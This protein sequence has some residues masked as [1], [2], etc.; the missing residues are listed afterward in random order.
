MMHLSYVSF[1]KVKALNFKDVYYQQH[2]PK[3]EDFYHF[4]PT[5][6]GLSHAIE[7]RKNFPV[8]RRL[9]V[10]VL[11]SHYTKIQPSEKQ[12]FNISKLAEDTT[13]TIVTAHQPS[14]MGGPAY[15]FY[16]IFS[17]L[18]LAKKLKETYPS[19]HFVPLFINGSE[20]HDFDEVKSL[21]LF[22]KKISWETDQKGS[23]GRFMTTG[24]EGVV[25]ELVEILGPNPKAQRLSEI[26][27]NALSGAKTYNDFVFSW[28][29]AF[30][31]DYGLIV[32]N[33]DD[34]RLKKSFIPIFTKEIT[35]RISEKL[36]HETQEKLQKIGF[37]PQAFARDINIFY[38]DGTSRERIYYQAG[39][40]KVNNSDLTFDEGQILEELNNFP[41]KFS[42][43]VVLRPLYEETILPNIAY[44]GG[45][46]ELAY[47]LERKSQFEAFGVFFP[48]LIRRNSVM[49]IPKSIQKLMEKLNITQ[50]DILL[51]EDKLI[52]RFL[53]ISSTENFHLDQESEKMIEI[54]HHI[55]EKAKNVDP[56]L[57]SYVLGEGHKVS[58]T[59]ENIENR[60]KRALKHKEE[61]NINQIKAIKHK[62]FPNNSLQ[63]RVDSF[64]QYLISEEDDLTEKLI[65]TLDPLEKTFLFVYL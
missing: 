51:D 63:E 4:A 6:E 22:G 49:M 20:D 21:Q 53:E 18:H 25:T 24:L 26:F 28:L 27:T 30:L 41:E 42:P 64:L 14:L 16:K 34:V 29:N 17:T 65:N 36:V 56:T 23:V 8:Q 7:A 58:K 3:M 44:I 9:L 2:F 33:M 31:G 54:F 43:N 12:L 47:W 11:T 55:A 59:L 39:V 52:T 19:Y 60:L 1:D 38:L 48:V 5:L 62:L 13:F 10:E 35:E 46:G 40:Y 37:K 61:T 57:E 45:G 50:D 15:Y 32:L